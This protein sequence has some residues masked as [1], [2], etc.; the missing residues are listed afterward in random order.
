MLDLDWILSET[1]S[2]SFLNIPAVFSLKRPFYVGLTEVASCGA[3]Y[4]KASP[5]NLANIIKGST[6]LPL[7]YRGFPEVD[8]RAVTDGGVA[9]GF[10]VQQAIRLG[11]KRIMVIRSRT[12][13]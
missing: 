13:S 8:G 2:R 1:L 11:A 6:A 5:N 9:V 3:A 10:P 4:V 12:A 7:L